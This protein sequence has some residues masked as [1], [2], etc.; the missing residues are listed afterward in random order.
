MEEILYYL[1]MPPMAAV[2]VVISTI[3]MY[4]VFIVMS[5][6]LGQRVLA[7]LSGYDLLIVIVM[8]ALIGRTMIGWV[9]T[10]ASGLLALCTLIVLEVIVGTIARRGR[11]A[12]VVNNPPILLLAHGE[13]IERELQRCHITEGEIRSRLR[14]AGIG[15]RSEVAAVILEPTGDLSVLKEGV[16]IDEEMLIG[17]RSAQYLR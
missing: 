10:L 15:S 12:A 17:V 14:R 2:G 9:P 4:A 7:K 6:L 11:F 1:G 16:P 3:A 8:G 5:R 13:Y